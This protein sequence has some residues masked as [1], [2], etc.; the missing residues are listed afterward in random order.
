MNRTDTCLDSAKKVLKENDKGT[1]TIPAAGLYPHQWLW[2]SCFIAIGLRHIDIDRAQTE[3]RSLVRG[4]WGNGMLP[5][6]I[7]DSGVRYAQD[8]KFWNSQLSPFAPDDVATSGITQPPVLAEAVLQIGQKLSKAERRSWYQTMY[9]SLVAYH[10]WLY[11]ERDPHGTGFVLQLHPYE[12]GLDST[13]PWV[14]QLHRHHRPWWASVLEQPRLI[15]A[16]NLFRRDTRRVPPGQRMDNL[17]ALLYYNMLRKLRAKH[18]DIRKILKRY[19][20]AIQDVTFNS[21]FIRANECLQEIAAFIKVPLPEELDER[22]SH[23]R[24]VFEQ[25]WDAYSGQYYSRNSSTNKPIRQPSIA[26]LMPLY[27]G[28][29]TKERAGQLVELLHKQDAFGT[30]Y[31]VPSVPVSSSYF[32]PLRYWQGP[33]WLNTNWMIVQGLVRYGFKK[34]A[35]IIR[36]KSIALVAEHGCYEYFSPI[37]GTP[38]GAEDFSWTA[39]LAIDL[40]KNPVKSANL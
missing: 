15:N 17:T 31:P 5:H 9:P 21:V 28:H 37:D 40:V 34:E 23:S 22:I 8:R 3:L 4:Q 7:F 32:D 1:F 18:Y 38:A 6:M 25:L 33:A 10:E 29:V 16:I 13:P 20:Y 19:P 12:T 30:N 27:A 24:Q 39:A 14:E 2:D 26:T 35:E 11:A 36:L